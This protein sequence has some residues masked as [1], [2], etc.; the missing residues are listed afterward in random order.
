M[1]KAMK[2][3]TEVNLTNVHT[4]KYGVTQ[5]ELFNTVEQLNVGDYIKIEYNKIPSSED[6]R[7][8]TFKAMK[9]LNKMSVSDFSKGR[10]KKVIA[11]ALNHH[12][13]ALKVEYYK[14]AKD[15]RNESG[16]L[17]F[18]DENNAWKSVDVRNVISITNTDGVKRTRSAQ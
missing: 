15:Y 3:K 9:E 16:Y 6:E 4:T 8:L 2:K 14:R 18:Q 7:K 5:R 10:H 11:H 12:K 13:G 1:K 17:L